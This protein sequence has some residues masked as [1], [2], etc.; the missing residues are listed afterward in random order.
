MK[1]IIAAFLLTVLCAGLL[2]SAPASAA[3]TNP[4]I[5]YGKISSM[6]GQEN[7][8]TPVTQSSPFVIGFQPDAVLS[9]YQVRLPDDYG[10]FSSQQII[11]FIIRKEGY[12]ATPQ[13]DYGQWSVGHG[14]RIATGD[15]S[16]A[17]SYI[18]AFDIP[19]SFKDDMLADFENGGVQSIY[20]SEELA[21][22]LLRDVLRNDFEPVVSK[23]ETK[24][25]PFSDS[26]YDAL[27][28]FTYNL[29]SGWTSGCR[30]IDWLKNPTTELDLVSA[31]GAWCWAGGQ[32]LAG[33]C[34]RRIDEARIFLYGDYGSGS[35]QN[36]RYLIYNG[37]GLALTK[38]Y[39]EAIGYFADGQAYGTLMR[40]YRDEYT[41]SGWWY[42]SGGASRELTASAIVSKNLSVRAKWV[43]GSE[44]SQPDPSEPTVPVEPSEPAE[45]ETKLPFLDV[46]KGQWFFNAVAFVYENELM[47]GVSDTAFSPDGTVS[48]AMAVAVLYRLD[49]RPAVS[50]KNTF[51]DVPNNTWYTD[52]VI[53]A[54]TNGIVAGIDDET[55]APNRSVTREQM[56]AF[57]YRYC[58]RYKKINPLFTTGATLSDFK[59]AGK[60][61]T[62]AVEAMDW[63]VQHGVLSGMGDGILDP[64]GTSRRA[65]LAV[66]LKTLVTSI[67]TES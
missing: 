5:N 51:S 39:K 27:V 48:R 62:Y 44:P 22:L 20:V 61:S 7:F 67:F 26:Q 49:G 32:I 63:C 11:D 24:Y 55:F 38:N 66:I 41:F 31:M 16:D 14:T 15:G 36:Y 57:L 60:I 40:P 17:P 6:E 37:N 58:V 3:E 50:G 28:S 33:L 47:S 59:D 10:N 56:A 53:W 52:A 64:K 13:W 8:P 34:Q 46:R 12:V 25:G 21:E 45:P 35:S 43:S 18:D 42:T 19:Q 30:V 65:Q 2:V 4:F 23:L 1:R 54:N 29:G 9:A